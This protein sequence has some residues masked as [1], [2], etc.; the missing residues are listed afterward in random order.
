METCPPVPILI[1]T[2]SL[3]FETVPAKLHWWSPEATVT[4]I[5]E[6]NPKIFAEIFD[7]FPTSE[8]ESI[9]GGNNLLFNQS[10]SI[11]GYCHCRE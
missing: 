1:A 2:V 5:S 10:L 11:N 3:M 8:H 9:I 6:L 7:K 4:G